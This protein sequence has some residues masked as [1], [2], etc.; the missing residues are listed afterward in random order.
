MA[1][2]VTGQTITTTE[3]TVEVTV[4]PSDPLSPGQHRFQ[5]VVRDDAGNESAPALVEIVVVDDRKPTAIIEAPRTVPFGTSFTLSGARS[6]DA[7][8]GRIVE[9]RWIRLS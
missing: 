7:P 3:P 6:V 2:F 8:P 5:L 9:Y 4:S 1:R